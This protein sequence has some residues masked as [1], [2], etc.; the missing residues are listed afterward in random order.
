MS[1]GSLQDG[2]SLHGD[3]SSTG[4]HQNSG[5]VNA[6]AQA[7]ARKILSERENQAVNGM[8]FV[9]TLLLTVTTIVVSGGMYLFMKNDQKVDFENQFNGYAGR[10]VDNFDIE[11]ERKL[12]ALDALAVSY[13]S[14]S[15]ASG[16]KFPNVT[17]PHVD[18][19]MANTRILADTLFITYMAL[20]TNEE[21]AGWEAYAA[22]NEKWMD[23][24]YLSEVDQRARQD[25]RFNLTVPERR[26][27]EGR[28]LQLDGFMPKIYELGE[29]FPPRPDGS[30]PFFA[31]WQNSPVMPSKALLN[32]DILVHPLIRNTILKMMET[33]QAVLDMAS[34]LLLKVDG[35]DDRSR[36]VLDFN[37][38]NGQY[39]HQIENYEGSPLSSLIYPVFDSFAEDR[40]LA[41]ALTTT[42]RIVLC[43]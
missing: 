24:A 37:L 29:N 13:T 41:G 15:L 31:Y 27:T 12:A 16:N 40:K 1:T 26:R 36:Q 5:N 6:Q 32:F 17:L 30:G 20:V 10:I 35:E 7:Q 8:R 19:R 2:D 39:R 4:H 11:L 22:E 33:E 23:E 25:A 42:V 9:V 21:R 43:S 34:N 18:I 28:D 38:A 14:H 3:Q